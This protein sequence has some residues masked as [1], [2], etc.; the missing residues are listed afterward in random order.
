MADAN[1]L[2]FQRLLNIIKDGK[3]GHIGK[4][5]RFPGGEIVKNTQKPI[6]S[7]EELMSAKEKVNS[8]RQEPEIPINDLARTDDPSSG[9]QEAPPFL[10]PAKSG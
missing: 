1:E 10:P 7:D 8:H 6:G 4:G 2:E 5:M 9:E 3:D